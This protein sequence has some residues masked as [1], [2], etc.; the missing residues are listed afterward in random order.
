MPPPSAAAQ[1]ERLS[2][3]MTQDNDTRATRAV[4][5]ENIIPEC[6]YGTLIRNMRIQRA[7]L[8]HYDAR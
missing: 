8:L 1:R 3:G 5:D 2:Y 6:R 4:I 7:V